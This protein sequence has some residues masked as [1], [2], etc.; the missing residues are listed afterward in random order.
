MTRRIPFGVFIAV[1]LAFA[2]GLGLAVSPYASSNPDGL[3]KVADE[4]GFLEK[5]RLHEIQDEAPIPDYAFPGIDNARLATG[6]AG[7]VGVLGIFV[8]AGGLAYGLRRLRPPERPSP[9][10]ENRAT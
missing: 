7:F 4:K 1:A 10:G 6:M 5:G 9:P 8:V 2:V 3:E